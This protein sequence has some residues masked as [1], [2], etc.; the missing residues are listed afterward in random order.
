LLFSSRRGRAGSGTA[1][2]E[3]LRAK[4]R[5]SFIRLL[6]AGRLT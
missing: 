3:D 6:M 1:A 2:S 5:H 4:S